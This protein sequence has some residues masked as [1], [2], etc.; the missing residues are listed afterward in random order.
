VVALGAMLLLVIT[1]L[2]TGIAAAAVTGE[3]Y[4]IG[5]VLVSHLATAPAILVV[6]GLTVGCFGLLPRLMTLF[7]WLAV[8]VIAFD[9]LFADLLDLPEAFRA[10]SPLWHLPKIPVEDFA[11]TPFL[12]L[13]GIAVVTAVLGLAG[14]RRREMNFR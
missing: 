10:L 4:L 11:V 8:A 9:D 2:G 1:G 13:L 14:F 5:D 7:G 12:V 6:L 3:G